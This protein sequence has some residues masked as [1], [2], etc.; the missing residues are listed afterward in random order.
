METH[1]YRLSGDYMPTHNIEVMGN[2]PQKRLVRTQV[3]FDK[4]GNKK[5][6]KHFRTHSC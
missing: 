3:V 2:P 1:F 5:V 6:I 4:K